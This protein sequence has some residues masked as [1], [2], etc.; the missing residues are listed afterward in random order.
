MH[1]PDLDMAV[2]ECRE[3]LTDQLTSQL[4]LLHRTKGISEVRGD[5]SLLR[6]RPLRT[7][8]AGFEDLDRLFHIIEEAD[9]LSCILV[10]I[11]VEEVV[12][13]EALRDQF[14]RRDRYRDTGVDLVGIGVDPSVKLAEGIGR[15]E[16]V[17]TDEGADLCTIGTHD[18]IFAEA[19]VGCTSH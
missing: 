15:I 1:L 2:E 17:C 19:Y 3:E 12:Y 5:K 4:L 14:I 6:R 10:V 8:S 11:G 13:G 7:A 9:L 16:V 18:T